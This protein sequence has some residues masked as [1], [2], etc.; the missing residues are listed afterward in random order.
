RGAS[1]CLGHR[2]S[3][4]YRAGPHAELQRRLADAAGDVR[5]RR[6]GGAD[7]QEGGGPRAGRRDA[8]NGIAEGQPSAPPRVTTFNG[9]GAY[10]HYIEGGGAPVWGRRFASAR[11]TG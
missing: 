4:A 5:R 6:T 8:L 11:R 2:R 7:H 10:I 9:R 3:P 1:R